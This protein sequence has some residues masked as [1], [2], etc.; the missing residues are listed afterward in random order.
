MRL[1]KYIFPL[2]VLLSFC[3]V[4]LTKLGVVSICP[5]G[6]VPISLGECRA[7]GVIKGSK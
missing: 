5:K 7:T 2:I 3:Y 1:L 4:L 6:E